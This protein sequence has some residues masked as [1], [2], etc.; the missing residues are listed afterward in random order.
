MLGIGI[1]QDE[2][3]DAAIAPAAWIEAVIARTRP[4]TPSTLSL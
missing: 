3:V 1:A 2:E 4:N